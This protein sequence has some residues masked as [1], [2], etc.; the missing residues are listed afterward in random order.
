MAGVS[1]ELSSN[2]PFDFHDGRLDGD[3]SQKMRIP[4]TIT[5]QGGDEEYLLNEP[6]KILSDRVPMS[7]P[8][9]I[10][11]GSYSPKSDIPR[12]LKDE[13]VAVNSLSSMITPPR[14]LT[15]EDT[16]SAH[17]PQTRTAPVSGSPT[18]ARG[19]INRRTNAARDIDDESIAVGLEVIGEGTTLESDSDIGHYLGGD[20]PDPRKLILQMQRLNSRVNELERNVEHNSVGFWSKMIFFTFTIINPIL[21][22]WLFWRR[23]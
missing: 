16:K 11:L 21:L 17:Y 3:L 18:A 14:T 13:M 10:E 9:R 8:D 4:Q 6:K 20:S 7:I 19:N 12:D 15:V 2:I 5:V 22:H 23:R 1:S